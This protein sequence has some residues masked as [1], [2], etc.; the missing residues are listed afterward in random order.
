MAPILA[1]AAITLAQQPDVP[2]FRA[3]VALVRLDAQVIDG[4]RIVADLTRDDFVIRDEGAPQDI[5]Y[6]GREAEPLSL[7]LL[8]DVSGSMRRSLQEMAAAARQA[9]APLR[10]ADQ[11]AVMLFAGTTTLSQEFTSEK[12]LAVRALELA[13]REDSLASGSAINAAIV[14][15]ARW[16]RR[17]LAGNPGRRAILI[18]T[19]NGGLN[20]QAPDETALE[21][22]YAADAV[23][24]AIVPSG[25][26][27]PSPP[28]PGR[29]VNP[30]FSPADVFR[31][32]RE[33]GGEVLRS[34]KAGA[35]F[36][37]LIERIRTRYSLHYRAPES[38]SAVFRRVQVELAPA[39]RKRHPRAEVRARVGYRVYP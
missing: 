39:A 28:A 6:F 30:D 2:T 4:R 17:Q 5:V 38:S 23:L 35:A 22:V 25:A 24:N 36:A 20:Y 26:R 3:G 15:A 29:T 7:L 14:E 11:V 37:E 9:L 31:L 10:P 27:P 12:K 8:L 1:L 33:T 32:A 13:Q 21:A 16:M 34:D 18:L 19:D